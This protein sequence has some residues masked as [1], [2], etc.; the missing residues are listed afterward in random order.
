MAAE[1]VGGNGG[2]SR[3][4]GQGG[5][6][7]TSVRTMRLTG[8]PHTVLIFF[9]F[10]QNWLNIKNLKRVSYLAP[11]IPNICMRI[12]WDIEQFSQLC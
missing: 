6:L 11:K 12:A 5:G 4:C 9:L 7:G 1:M 8:G 2:R 10:I 3:G